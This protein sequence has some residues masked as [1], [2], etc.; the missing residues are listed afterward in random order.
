LKCD[1]ESSHDTKGNFKQK[2][3]FL[4]YPKTITNKEELE[5]EL[6]KVKKQ[7]FALDVGKNEKDVRCVSAPIRNYQGKVYCCY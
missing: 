3:F 5:K 1:K 4:F 2:R 7:S 6:S